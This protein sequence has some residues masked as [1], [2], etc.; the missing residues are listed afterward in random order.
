MGASSCLCINRIPAEY[1]HRDEKGWLLQSPCQ[2]VQFHLFGKSAT[3][4]S[5]VTLRL[6][7]VPEVNDKRPLFEG[8]LDSKIIHFLIINSVGGDKIFIVEINTIVIQM[9]LISLFL[10]LTVFVPI[11]EKIFQLVRQFQIEK[12]P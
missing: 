8:L 4:A 7:F 11:R 6:I 2:N 5:L 9:L 10:F 3:L 12:S 1:R